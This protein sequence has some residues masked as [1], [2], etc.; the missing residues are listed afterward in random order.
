MNNTER[1]RLS[2]TGPGN[3]GDVCPTMAGRGGR[4]LP[5][6]VQYVLP[7][8]VFEETVCFCSPGLSRREANRVSV[9]YRS[10]FNLSAL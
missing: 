3:R 4:G 5:L 6:P 8:S 2:A 10:S 7:P 1:Y 9:Y